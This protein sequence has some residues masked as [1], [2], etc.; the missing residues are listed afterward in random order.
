VHGSGAGEWKPAKRKAKYKGGKG[1]PRQS[2]TKGEFLVHGWVLWD[3]CFGACS[4]GV[5]PWVV[6]S[7]PL[8][9]LDVTETSRRGHLLSLLNQTITEPGSSERGIYEQCQGKG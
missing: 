5:C 7:K 3:A 9:F 1:T 6:K 8:Y 2:P 4:I